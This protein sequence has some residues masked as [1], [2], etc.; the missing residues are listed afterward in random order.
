MAIKIAING[1]GRIGRCVLRAIYEENLTNEF[2]IIAINDLGNP[3]VNAHLTKYDTTHGRFNQDVLSYDNIMKINDDHIKILSERDPSCLP[4]SAL[5]IDIVFECTG[6]FTSKRDCNAHIKA[7]AKKVLISAPGSNDIDATVVY[8]VN[9]NI[10]NSDMT[11]ISNASCT[12]NCLAP[13]VKVINDSIGIESGLMTTV[14]AYT[15][16]QKVVDSY[17]KDLHRSR[18]ASNNMIPTKTGAA[19]AIGAVL[20][21]LKGRLDGLA[22]RVPTINVSV[23]D[24]TFISKRISSVEEV[25]KLLKNASETEALKHVLCYNEEY[26]VSSDFNHNTCPSIFDSTQTH[27]VGNL[28]KVLSWYDNEWGFSNQMLRTAKAWSLV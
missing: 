14:H 2:K 17:H 26:L 7:G 5:G 9:H 8:G 18:A 10:L 28:I 1:Y 6:L 16:D 4:W 27:A 12:T 15:N 25:N 21:E 23:F 3:K 20:P 24:L 13:V 11:V 22:I 19:L